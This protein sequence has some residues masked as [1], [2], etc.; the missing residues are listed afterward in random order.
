MGSPEIIAVIVLNRKKMHILMFYRKALDDKLTINC[1]RHITVYISLV[2]RKPVFWFCDQVE[3]RQRL[4][5][6]GIETR[7]IILSR[8]RTKKALIRL[9]R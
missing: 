7:G 9:L 3:A 1:N 4:E 6:S 2:T 5:I 8:Q